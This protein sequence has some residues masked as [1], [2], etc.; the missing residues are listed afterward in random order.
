MNFRKVFFFGGGGVQRTLHEAS[1]SS[2]LKYQREN[3]ALFF[4]TD[5]H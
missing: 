2:M 5:F 1:M 4:S 3:Q